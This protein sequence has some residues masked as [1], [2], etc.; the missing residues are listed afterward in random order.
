[1]LVRRA[2]Y[3][4]HSCSAVTA[5]EAASARALRAMPGPAPCA[6]FASTS[7]PACGRSCPHKPH[8]LRRLPGLQRLPT[9]SHCCPGCLLSAQREPAACPVTRQNHDGTDDGMHAMLEA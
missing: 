2:A 6:C 5:S 7:T 3:F 1:M 9:T 8:T 4:T